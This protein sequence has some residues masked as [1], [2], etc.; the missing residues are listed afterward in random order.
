M[1]AAFLPLLTFFISLFVP[2]K[3]AGK[4]AAAIFNIG[5]SLILSGALF[6]KVWN[7]Q[8]FHFRIEWVTI[9][10]FTLYTGILLN[11]LSVLMM[12]LV[13]GIALL[14]HVYS[15]KY[16]QGD[17][18]LHR[19]WAYL[20]LFCF[21]MLGLVI[22]DNLL[23]MYM[24][25]ELV[26]FSSYLL[27]G[28][29]FTRHTAVLA[30]KKA[31][32]VNRIGDLGFLIGIMIT[33]TQFHTLDLTELFGSN[34][35][36][37]NAVVKGGMWQSQAGMM[38]AGWLTA[39]GIAFFLGAVAKSAQFPLHTWLPDAMEGPT[40]VSS[41]IHAATMV[42]AGVFLL[43][44]IYPLFGDDVLLIIAITGAFTAFMAATI[45]LVQNDIKR[46]LAFSTISQLGFMMLAMGTG[47]Q[48]AGL[49]H[50][51]T[52]AFFKCLL[53]L[54]AGAVIH[55][56]AHV[57][58]K[59]GIA[60]DPQDIRLMGGL[61]KRMPVTFATMVIASLALTGLPLM[62]GYLSKD[63]ILI[64]AFEW[65]EGHSGL[66]KLIPYSALLT[67][68]LTAFYIS[69]LIFKVFF[70]ELRL[71]QELLVHVH[72]HEAPSAMKYVLVVLAVFCFFPA[73][74]LNP[75]LFED[76]WILKGFPVT[77]S[78][79]RVNLFHTIIPL[80]VNLIAMLL[81]F[82]AW[83]WYGKQQRKPDFSA[84]GLFRFAEGQW[85]IDQFYTNVLVSGFVSVSR[86]VYRFDRVVV[87]GLV[88]IFARAA[89]A[90]S[91]MAAWTD[92]NI[93]DRIVNG[94]AYLTGQ[95]GRFF[96]HFQTG[97]LQHYFVTMLLV[98]LAFFIYKYYSGTI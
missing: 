15:T 61:R 20:G 11:N 43:A 80:A 19:Y 12:L 96:G 13:S 59:Q 78:M 52:H 35:L 86:L 27:I 1:L 90:L 88:N 6:L 23:L 72:I 81:I 31:F 94:A 74:S 3:P 4:G 67:S 16:M 36:V 84:S 8:S 91:V 58:D 14:V 51:V 73:F 53:F 44:R 64:N 89:K 54:A 22:A 97:R 98:V 25:W 47:A 56:M 83:L 32:I 50:L 46:I 9:G 17:P 38:P 60:F 18:Y 34:G 95:G 7:Q 49:F 28:F 33:L 24:A 57:K 79:T 37:A 76:A 2:V 21:A 30:N 66:A 85:Y 42:A 63:S 40:S 5:L 55:E 70:G 10:D 69:R 39:A 77:D 75:F 45:A 26:G 71:E 92:R 87:D 93:V 68:W 82:I 48:A 29:W 41:L 65:A 62:S